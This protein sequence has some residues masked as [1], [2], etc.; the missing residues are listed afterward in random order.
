MQEYPEFRA[1]IKSGKDEAD[2]NVANS[3]Y[4]RAN[5]YS[6]KAEKIAFDKEGNALRAEYIERYPPDTALAIY[7]LGRVDGFNQH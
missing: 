3:L 4:H 7:W 1:S 5:G 6:H 2:A